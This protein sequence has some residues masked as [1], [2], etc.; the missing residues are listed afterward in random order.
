MRVL[1]ADVHPKVRWALRTFIEE[2]PELTIVGEASEADTL[3]SQALKLQPDLILLEWELAGRPVHKLVSALRALVLGV[4]V[5]VLG[6]R[7]ESE[8][9]ALVA[10]ADGFVSKADGPGQLLTVLR[11]MM[12]EGERQ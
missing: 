7:P 4:Q 3:M 11:G 5:V 10:G 12:V 1:L 2:E 9:D 8:R 6:S